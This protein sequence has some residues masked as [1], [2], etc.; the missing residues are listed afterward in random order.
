M[1]QTQNPTPLRRRSMAMAPVLA[2][3]LL[4]CCGGPP[5]PRLPTPLPDETRPVPA[6]APQTIYIWADALDNQFDQEA[7]RFFDLSRHGRRLFGR[8]REAFNRNAF[9]E[10]DDSSWFVNRNAARPLSLTEIARGPNTVEGPDTSGIWT[11]VSAKTEGVTPG[12]T[13]KDGRGDRY[14]IKLDAFGSPEMNSGAEIICTKLFHAA[15]YNVPENYLAYFYPERLVLGENV[16]FTDAMGRQR[17]MVQADLEQIVAGIE[18]MPDGRFRAIASKFLKGKILGPFRYRGYRK[19]DA[20]DIVPHQH[21]R[22]LRGLGVFSSWLNHYDTKANNSL[23]VYVKEGY[24]RHY[25]IDFGS[26]LGS[27]GDEPMPAWVGHENQF[28]PLRIAANI[29]TL[30]LYVRPQEKARPSPYAAVGYFEAER[31]NPG[32]Y[33]SIFPNP[34]FEEMTD[35]DGYWGAKL[36]MSFSDAQI[37]TAVRQARYSDPAAERYMVETLMA[38]R[39]LVGRYWFGRLAPLDRFSLDEGILRFAD[40]AVVMGLASERSQYRYA[41]R[42]LAKSSKSEWQALEG[43][44]A[45]GIL[46]PVDAVKQPLQVLDLQVRRPKG[47]WSKSVRLFLNYAEG[48][49]KILK[50]ERQP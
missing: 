7:K 21:R 22:E 12:F 35:A 32:K 30:G 48:R 44:P 18:R 8:P 2:S 39:D 17:P 45:E 28:D 24:V 34:A 1:T 10:V 15:G 36:V 26:T 3:L 25:L 31:F 23:D 5:S 33:R 27:Q 11:V 49:W 14:V 9:D 38:R 19:D 20:N 29:L 4:V 42:G 40:L 47:R 6:P 16:K 50:I 37:E 46:L 13:I 41:S 43:A